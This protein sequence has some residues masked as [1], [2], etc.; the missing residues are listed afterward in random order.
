MTASVLGATAEL[1]QSVGA[2]R[3]A[4]SW[5]CLSSINRVYEPR[6]LGFGTFIDRKHLA[7]HRNDGRSLSKA[8]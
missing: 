5:T 3:S 8:K 4:A 7:A 6:Y 2:D 1:Y